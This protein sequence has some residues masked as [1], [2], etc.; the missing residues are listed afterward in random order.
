ML[1]FLEKTHGIEVM[2][3]GYYLLVLAL[4]GYGAVSVYQVLALFLPVGIE[5]IILQVFAAAIV[6]FISTF[7]AVEW[8]PMAKKILAESEKYKWI[9]VV[10]ITSVIFAGI[11]ECVSRGMLIVYNTNSTSSYIIAIV[12]GIL[13]WVVLGIAPGVTV[14][15]DIYKRDRHNNEVTE[16]REELKS[17]SLNEVTQAVKTQIAEMRKQENGNN[18]V[19]NKYGYLLLQQG[20]NEEQSFINQL[21]LPETAETSKTAF[22]TGQRTTRRFSSEKPSQ[23]RLKAGNTNNGRRQKRSYQ[24]VTAI[25]EEYKKNK[26][27]PKDLSEAEKTNYR[28]M[29]R[30]GGLNPADAFLDNQTDNSQVVEQDQNP[31]PNGLYVVNNDVED[32]RINTDG[33]QSQT[34]DTTIDLEATEIDE[35]DNNEMRFG[36]A[37]PF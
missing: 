23:L 10:L 19:I 18:V 36:A 9:V 34:I 24:E 37:R 22:K 25:F 13:L 8:F 3:V 5:S 14:L 17:L 4:S 26:K 32:N 27:W 16:A 35:D 7:I 2:F 1:K 12:L 6:F 33:L 20:T 30:T 11:A 21:L 31:N 29:L 28:K 15:S